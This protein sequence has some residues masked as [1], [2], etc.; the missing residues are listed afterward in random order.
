MNALQLYPRQ[1]LHEETL[2]ETYFKRSAILGGKRPFC[3]F[4]PP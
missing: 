2:Q 3:V 4:E 1:F